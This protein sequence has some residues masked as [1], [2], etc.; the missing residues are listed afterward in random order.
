MVRGRGRR[1]ADLIRMWRNR[2]V[3]G[4]DFRVSVV[5]FL[6]DSTLTD[7]MVAR[8]YR[9]GRSRVAPISFS[10]PSVKF[11][12]RDGDE[13]QRCFEQTLEAFRSQLRESGVDNE[14]IVR[15]DASVK[16]Y[17]TLTPIIGFADL[18]LFPRILDLWRPLNTTFHF[19]VI[20]ADLRRARKGISRS[21]SDC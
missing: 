6:P 7:W 19:D 2:K 5:C 13:R 9:P 1:P 17:T 12:A 15:H 8:G 20:N 3:V 18:F 10:L 14:F 21:S 11:S 4:D 16:V